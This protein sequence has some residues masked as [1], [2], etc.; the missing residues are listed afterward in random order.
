M[1]L[2]RIIEAVSMQPYETYV[3]QNVLTPLGISHT[4]LGSTLPGNR[5][6]GEV[7]YHSDWKSTSV[8]DGQTS[9]FWPDGGWNLENM[10]SHGGW[11]STVIDMARFEASF[12]N[13]TNH[14]VLEQN[15][16]NLM[17]MAPPGV[18][19]ERYYAMGWAI[20]RW[21]GNMNTWHAGS[22]DG[23]LSIL[24]RRFDGI[25]WFVVF[26]ERDSMSDP[27]GDSY[28]EID[29]LLHAAADAVKTWPDHDLFQQLP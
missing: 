18:T 25:D 28:W 12:D 24:V 9:V 1:L 22:L 13:Q 11:V 26:N 5:L 23:T 20:V 3:Q 29:G 8:F 15:M 14:P 16:I 21:D 2:G 17:F 6:P 10:D 27:S 7:T 4:Q 19:G